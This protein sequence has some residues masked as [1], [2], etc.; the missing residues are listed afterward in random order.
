MAD[1][2]I[3]QLK[4]LITEEGDVLDKELLP[5]RLS[6]GINWFLKTLY[7][8]IIKPLHQEARLLEKKARV[9]LAV[10]LIIEME[11]ACWEKTNQLQNADFPDYGHTALGILYSK[12]A[13]EAVTVK[14]S[15]KVPKGSSQ[16]ETLEMFK[17]GNSVAAI[18][19][20]RLNTRN[21]SRSPR[22]VCAYRS[23]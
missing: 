4:S 13:F 17:A 11:D 5:K 6:N 22:T 18:A 14:K 23:N 21:Y 2:F 9:K 3:L 10:K 20:S 12:T 7:E 19:N 15:G 8:D 16:K 1:K